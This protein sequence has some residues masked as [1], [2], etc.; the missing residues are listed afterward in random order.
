MRECCEEIG[1]AGEG[2]QGGSGVSG[3]SLGEEGR[4]FVEGGGVAL[5]E[6]ILEIAPQPF[7]GIHSGA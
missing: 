1:K 7:D 6:P 2:A 4:E 5:G 3:Q